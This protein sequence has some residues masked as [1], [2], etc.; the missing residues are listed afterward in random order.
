MAKN[1]QL[2][3]R[4][5][6]KQFNKLQQWADHLQCTKSEVIRRL[7][8]GL[9]EPGQQSIDAEQIAAILKMLSE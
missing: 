7:V 5:T 1:N 3:I 2:P 8:D 9:P 6:D 4:F